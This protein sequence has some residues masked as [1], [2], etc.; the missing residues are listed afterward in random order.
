MSKRMKLT[1]ERGVS[2]DNNKLWNRPERTPDDMDIRQ[3]TALQQELLFP[4][5]RNLR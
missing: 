4:F 1:V 5:K 3:Y 2:R